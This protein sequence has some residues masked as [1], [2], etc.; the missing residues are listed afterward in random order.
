SIV[1]TTCLAVYLVLRRA[2]PDSQAVTTIGLVWT[3]TVPGIAAAL[4][5]GL[6][7]RHL[8]VGHVLTRISLGLSPL[9]PRELRDTLADALD[10]AGIEVLTPAE[11]PG[12]WRDT[13]GHITSA[14]PADGHHVMTTIEDTEGIAA[15]L[16]HDPTLREDEELL[17]AVRSLVLATLEHQRVTSRLVASLT[18][19]EDSR[20]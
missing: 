19:L 11:Q 17:D 10:D 8:M 12:R 5:I 9:D 16:V 14:S 2:A 15:A 7:R 6:V 1:F 4:L 13:E 18:E 3:L 20:K